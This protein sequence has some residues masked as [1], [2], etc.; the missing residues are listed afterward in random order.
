MCEKKS[1]YKITSTRIA[2]YKHAYRGYEIY[3]SILLHTLT[4]GKYTLKGIVSLD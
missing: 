4:K 1:I 3:K 2:N